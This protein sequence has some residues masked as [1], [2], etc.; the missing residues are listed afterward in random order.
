MAAILINTSSQFL[1]QFSSENKY[2]KIFQ[3]KLNQEKMLDYVEE[4]FRIAI[5]F[6]SLH[7]NHSKQFLYCYKKM[8]NLFA[9]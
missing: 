8:A 3:N 9:V 4:I 6:P 7:A 5:S 1:T 2:F